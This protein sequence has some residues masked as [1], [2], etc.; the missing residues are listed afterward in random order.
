MKWHCQSSNV[1][2]DENT[3]TWKLSSSR[4]ILWEEAERIVS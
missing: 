2:D 4:E 3:S 1:Y